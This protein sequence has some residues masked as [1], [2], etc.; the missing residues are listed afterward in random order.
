M[1]IILIVAT[2]LIVILAIIALRSGVFHRVEITEKEIG[3]FKIAYEEYTGPYKETG[4]IQDRIY[5]SLR[6]E[7]NIETYRGIGI[8]YDDPK[9]TPAEECRSKVGCIIEEQDY[10]KIENLK[11]KYNILNIARQ[12]MIYSEFPY[13]S[14]LSIMTGIF[15]VYPKIEQYVQNNDYDYHESIEIYDVP[16]KKIIYLM[17][18]S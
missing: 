16:N 17:K 18:K 12:R 10:D 15:K 9:E 14:K 7:D 6:E 8:Y 5:S 11:D 2:L 4:K 13:K 1:K 3:P